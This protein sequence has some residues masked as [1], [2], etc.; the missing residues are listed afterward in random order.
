MITGN[1][2]L[3]GVPLAILALVTLISAAFGYME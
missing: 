1:F 3:V 2:L